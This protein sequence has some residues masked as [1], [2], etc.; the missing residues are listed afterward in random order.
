MN[1]LKAVEKAGAGIHGR[2]YR[3]EWLDHRRHQAA[4]FIDN[5]SDVPRQIDPVGAGLV[6]R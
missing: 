1:F 4:A 5:E 6:R 2:S 3:F